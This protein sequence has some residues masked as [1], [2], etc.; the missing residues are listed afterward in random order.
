MKKL[1][2]A[3]AAVVS[4]GAV[5]TTVTAVPAS[6]AVGIAVGPHGVRVGEYHRHHYWH[7][8]YYSRWHHRHWR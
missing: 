8:H 6:A 3:A 7:R 5:V 2:L 1:I 4:L